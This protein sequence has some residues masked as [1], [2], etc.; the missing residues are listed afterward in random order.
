LNGLASSCLWILGQP[1]AWPVST[2][3][4]MQPLRPGAPSV[5]P[6]GKL[7]ASPTR[8][9]GTRRAGRSPSGIEALAGELARLDGLRDGGLKAVEDLA[10]AH[11]CGYVALWWWWWHGAAGCLVAGDDASGA[12]VVPRR[13]P[14]DGRR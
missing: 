10:E 12:I 7:A 11:L 3:F 6:G 4:S 1:G 5:L 8:Q 13:A 9:S 2:T 14:G